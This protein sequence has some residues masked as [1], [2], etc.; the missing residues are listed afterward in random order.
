MGKRK[1]LKLAELIKAHKRV[2][3][4]RRKEK[5]KKLYRLALQP[6]PAKPLRVEMTNFYHG[7]FNTIKTRNCSEEQLWGDLSREQ[8]MKLDKILNGDF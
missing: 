4:K 8:Q 6:R 3:R 2:Y 1:W 5:P 7:K